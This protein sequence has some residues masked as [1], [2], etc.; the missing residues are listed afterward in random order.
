VIYKAGP[1]LAAPNLTFGW[2]SGGSS[3]V[4]NMILEWLSVSNL[5]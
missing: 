4:N 5:I 2:M 1:A 3:V